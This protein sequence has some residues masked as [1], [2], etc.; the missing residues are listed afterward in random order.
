MKKL[1]NFR[2]PVELVSALDKASTSR[3]MYKQNSKNAFVQ[4]AL[5]EKIK[6]IAEKEGKTFQ[7]YLDEAMEEKNEKQNN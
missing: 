4:N 1:V 7:Q 2:F 5:E 3:N 6:D